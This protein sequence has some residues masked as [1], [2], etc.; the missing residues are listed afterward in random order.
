[1]VKGGSVQGVRRILAAFATK[2][3]RNLHNSAS[4]PSKTAIINKREPENRSPWEN[5]MIE[6][7]ALEFLMAVGL[8]AIAAG[9]L[10]FSRAQARATPTIGMYG[11]GR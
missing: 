9:G 8:G 5:K 10:L 4:N 7:T 3:P 1:M 6:V 11:R 2:S